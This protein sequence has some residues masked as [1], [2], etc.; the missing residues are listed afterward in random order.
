MQIS[1]Y[2]FGWLGYVM[3]TSIQSFSLSIS[4]PRLDFDPDIVA[5]LDD[6]FD[7]DNPDNLLE[8]D[9]I[10][11]A[12]EPGNGDCRYMKFTELLNNVTI[13]VNIANI[14]FSYLS[15]RKPERIHIIN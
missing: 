12:S 9:F 8:D 5:A 14:F 2:G 13:T 11:K 10:L 3:E 1:T 6:D 7:F 15:V 4:G